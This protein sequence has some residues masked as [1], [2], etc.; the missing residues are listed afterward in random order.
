MNESEIW[1]AEKEK[2]RKELLQDVKKTSV[3]KELFTKS[4]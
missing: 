3:V 1:E 4:S 2:E